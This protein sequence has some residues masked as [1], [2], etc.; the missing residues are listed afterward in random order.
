MTNALEGIEVLDFGANLA[1]PFAPQMMSDLGASVIKI[2]EPWSDAR[3]MGRGSSFFGCQRGKRSLAID[4]KTPQGTEVMHRL[5]ARAD[6]IHHNL[7]PGVAERLKY[8]Y[9]TAK[10]LN[11]SIIYCHTTG[12]GSTGPNADWPGWDQFGQALGGAEYHGGGCEHGN[13]PMWHRYGQ[14]DA[15]NAMHSLIGVLQALYHRDRTGE[16]QFVETCIVNGGMTINSDL[17]LRVDGPSDRPILDA[18]QRGL[19]DWYRLYETADGWITV[20]CVTDDQRD[21]M[22]RALGVAPEGGPGGRASDA[23]E[24]AFRRATAT[25]WQARLDEAGVPAEISRPT[26]ARDIFDDPEA[27]DKGWVVAYQHPEVGRLEQVGSLLELSATP[28]R[29]AGPPPALGQHTI[30][31]LAELG[32]SADEATVLKDKRI[33]N[34]PN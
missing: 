34:F 19:G 4:L 24:A 26:Y 13:P 15:V 23:L 17:Y 21:R 30:E 8:D 14:C 29:I 22:R 1:G 20:A 16:G 33:V 2:E 7:R 6:I 27:I 18:E 32:Y 3:T 25:E 11:P 9:E 12:W 31:I 10:R 28:G 5:I